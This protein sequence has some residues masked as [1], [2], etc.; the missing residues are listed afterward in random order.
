MYYR[1]SQVKASKELS[2]LCANPAR[3]I[4][5]TH[6]AYNNS[7]KR[8]FISATPMAAYLSCRADSTVEQQELPCFVFWNNQKGYPSDWRYIICLIFI[9]LVPMH[10]ISV[11]AKAH[12]TLTLAHYLCK[13]TLPHLLERN[14]LQLFRFFWPLKSPLTT[15]TATT[16]CGDQCRTSTLDPI[17]RS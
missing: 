11:V 8:T 16:T 15:S 9:I 7:D 3:F 1:N 17:G 5:K 6:T 14:L 10:P 4:G 13:C 12:C 2:Q